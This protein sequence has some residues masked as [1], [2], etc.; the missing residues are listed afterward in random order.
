MAKLVVELISKGSSAAWFFHWS[1]FIEEGLVIMLV[2]YRRLLEIFCESMKKN[3][4]GKVVFFVVVGITLF[5]DTTFE[6]SKWSKFV[7]TTVCFCV[8]FGDAFLQ[9]IK[10]LRIKNSERF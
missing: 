10:E 3:I 5:A 9:I 2:K 7:V 6:W 8:I 1:D 4:S